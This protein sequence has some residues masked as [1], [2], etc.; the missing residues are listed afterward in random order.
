MNNSETLLIT[1]YIKKG[2]KIFPNNGKLP[3]AI[4]EQN[5][6]VNDIGIIDNNLSYPVFYNND[7]LILPGLKKKEKLCQHKKKE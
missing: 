2:A 6:D 7:F 5:F 3:I 4:A 1:K